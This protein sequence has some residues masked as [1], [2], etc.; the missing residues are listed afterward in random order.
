MAKSVAV[1]ENAR[2]TRPALWLRKHWFWLGVNLAAAFPL[3]Q[4]AWD[5]WREALSVNPID[6]I[7]DRTGKAAIMLLFFSLA[8]TPA[9]TI[10]GVR[11]AVTVRKA[12]GMWA[13]VYASVHLLNFV[14]YD[15]GFD[16]R[17]ILEDGLPTK[18]YILV[19]LLAF[20][21]LVPLA[22]TSTKGWQKR[23][24]QRWKQLHKL[25]YVAC[26]AAVLHFFWLAK[27][28]EDWEPALYAVV[29]SLLLAVRIPAVR[30][31]LVSMR[32]QRQ[33]KQQSHGDGTKRTATRNPA[34]KST[35]P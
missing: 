29:L 28:A 22:I 21:V 18:P 33:G 30:R 25:V 35:R 3:V 13:F 10:F 31:R 9:N 16:L 15:Y 27:A 1:R 5:F 8:C 24:G 26:V 32:T 34:L 23:L 20:L 12:L 2:Q 19:G 11:Q 7:T 6:D 4:L 14:G 17:F